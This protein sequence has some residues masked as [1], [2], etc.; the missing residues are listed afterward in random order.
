ME[1][2]GPGDV[3]LMLPEG[4]LLCLCAADI[5]MGGGHSGTQK[6][7]DQGLTT[8]RT[9]IGDEEGK[10][11]KEKYRIKEKIMCGLWKTKE[12]RA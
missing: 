4:I 10:G 8:D 12:T 6:G 3:A 5:K 1:T 9:A 2:A 11:K 7:G